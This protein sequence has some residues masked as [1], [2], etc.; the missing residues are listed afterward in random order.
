M[1]ISCG[2]SFSSSFKPSENNVTS[3][4]DVLILFFPRREG[5]RG[6][7]VLGSGSG[8]ET[9]LAVVLLPSWF[10]ILQRMG[11]P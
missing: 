1:L 10:M 5:V 4:D 3:F 9:P 6:G 7:G 11:R 8:F 2:P